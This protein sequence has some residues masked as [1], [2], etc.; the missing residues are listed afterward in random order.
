[1]S[2]AL[3]ILNDVTDFGDAAVTLPLLLTTGAVLAFRDGPGRFGWIVAIG[4]AY[5]VILALKLA[6]GAF[7]SIGAPIEVRSPSGHTATAA[8]AYGG[9]ALLLSGR[10]TIGLATASLVAAL[11]GTSRVALD[12]HT[13]GEVLVGAT[14]GIGGVLMLAV[15]SRR[16]PA[17]S[18]QSAVLLLALSSAVIV[19]G[20][21]RH[22][23]IEPRLLHIEQGL[24]F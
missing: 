12:D 6:F 9:L 3:L 15:V 4:G 5:A 18:R 14:V 2:A 1:M 24:N 22:A 16:A 20:Y 10:R 8:A 13:I 17:L 23:A 11:V 21:G 7:P 19:A